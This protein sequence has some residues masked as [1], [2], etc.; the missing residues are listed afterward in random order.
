[1]RSDPR[2]PGITRIR[3]GDGFRYRDPTGADIAN[4]Q[5]LLRIQ[6]LAIPPAWTDVW[7][8]PDPVGHIQATGIDGRGR[9]QYR[10]HELWQ[11]RRDAEKFEHMLRFAGA[12]PG[13]PRTARIAARQAGDS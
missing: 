12:L 7:I 9:T 6:A 1:M 13:D 8:S 4:T 11:Q 10:Y 3:A 5:T 2:G